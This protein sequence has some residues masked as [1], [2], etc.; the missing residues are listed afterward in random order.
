M[1][2]NL[3]RV[4]DVLLQENSVTV[5]AERLGTSPPAVSRS[6][7]TLRRVTGDPLLVR[8]GQGMVPTQRAIE[9][10]DTLSALLRQADQI[11][12]P[13]VEFDPRDL[14]R[15]FAVQAADLFLTGWA[16][17]LLERLRRCAPGIDVVF[18]PESTEGTAALRRG[19]VDVELGVLQHLDPESRAET[20]LTMPVIGVAG[21]G[22]PLF[23]APIDAARFAAADHIGVSRRGKLRGPIDDALARLGLDRR[24]AVV[25]PSHTSAILLA[26]STDLVA[27]TAANWLSALA[28]DL[29]LRTF[30]IPLE[31]PLVE[32]GIAWHPR[33]DNDPAHRW[34]RSQLSAIVLQSRLVTGS[35]AAA[36]RRTGDDV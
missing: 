9:I 13:G 12:R 23:D 3:L 4:L 16:V 17:P 1:D 28:T 7:S 22:N 6:L 36:D 25:V 11:L 31:L 21:E 20:L 24:V 5:A 30:P 18:V 15:T 29:G 8:A 34:F 10:R 32:I 2:L 26:R 14:R 33:N 19:D 27:L 35:D